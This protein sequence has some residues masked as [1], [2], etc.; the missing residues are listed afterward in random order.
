[1][2]ASFEDILQERTHKYRRS[3]MAICVILIAIYWL[4]N[5]EFKDLALFGI[6]SHARSGAVAA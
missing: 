4:P 5:L 1:M 3:L 2:A 6:K